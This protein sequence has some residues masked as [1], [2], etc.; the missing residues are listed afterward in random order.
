MRDL[1]GQLGEAEVP[2]PDAWTGFRLMPRRIEFWSDGQDRMHDRLLYVRS[3]EQ[4]SCE[5]LYP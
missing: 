3:G 2:L 4:W 1:A 5:R